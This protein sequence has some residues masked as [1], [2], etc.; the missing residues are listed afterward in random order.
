M[1]YL[2]KFFLFFVSVM[3]LSAIEIPK[4]SMPPCEKVD[5][6]VFLQF[7]P[8]DPT[9]FIT[10]DQIANT[11]LQIVPIGEDV[12][13]YCFPMEEG[14]VQLLQEYQ[15]THE[16]IRVWL[17]LYFGLLELSDFSLSEFFQ[18]EKRKRV[19]L[20][21]LNCPERVMQI[22]QNNIELILNA[23]GVYV[24]ME[25]S[26][27]EELNQLMISSNFELMSQCLCDGTHQNVFYARKCWWKIVNI[28]N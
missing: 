23:S 11:A 9:I 4:D 7:L 27:F 6:S 19:D 13:I 12:S 18:K 21:Y 8:S 5:L 28:S 3:Q 2:R 15:K 24:K 25:N 1:E 22:L 26:T 20:F 16:E 17:H 14:E 10:G